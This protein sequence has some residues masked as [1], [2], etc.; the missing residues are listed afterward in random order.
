VGPL[1]AATDL[2]R[3]PK[4]PRNVGGDSLMFADLSA[5][6]FHQTAGRSSSKNLD[7]S[8][9]VIA[10]LT[11]RISRVVIAT[12]QSGRERRVVRESPPV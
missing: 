10:A 11:G 7:E 8:L 12:Q 9:E 3:I 6:T 1:P 2:S 4:G 5:Q